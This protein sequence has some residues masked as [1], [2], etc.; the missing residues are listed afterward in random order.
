M[1]GKKRKIDAIDREMDVSEAIDVEDKS[2]YPW[3]CYPVVAFEDKPEKFQREVFYWRNFRWKK[4]YEWCL[5]IQ[6]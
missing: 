4:V 6:N 3:C 5:L 2:Y 1:A